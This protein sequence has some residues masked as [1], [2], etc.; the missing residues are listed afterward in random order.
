MIVS[1][2]RVAVRHCFPTLA[3]QYISFR[4]FSYRFADATA[5]SWRGAVGI[6]G[7][8]ERPFSPHAARWLSEDS[9]RYIA[10][11]RA[12]HSISMLPV[13]FPTLATYAVFRS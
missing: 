8:S 2:A 10:V 9:P 13:C 12:P 11:R 4:A 6:G 5:G 7:R 1:Y 3:T